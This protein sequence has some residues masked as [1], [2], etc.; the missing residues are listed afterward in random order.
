MS[1]PEG[2]LEPLACNTE[3]LEHMEAF[4]LVV[5]GIRWKRQYGLFLFT[6][7]L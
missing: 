6:L 4:I 7:V 5:Q 2:P 1:I 3:A